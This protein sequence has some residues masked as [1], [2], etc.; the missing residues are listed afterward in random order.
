MERILYTRCSP[1][2]D[3]YEKDKINYSE[4][5]GISAVSAGYY[6]LIPHLQA[7]LLV[8]TVSEE[9][10]DEDVYEKIYEYVHLGGD[11]YLLNAVESL[12]LCTEPRVNGRSHRPI[13]LS[14]AIFGEFEGKPGA[15]LTD[16]NFTLDQVSQNER[17][18]MD[19]TQYP[20]P[21]PL[22]SVNESSLAK[23][24]VVLDEKL[25]KAFCPIFAYISAQL[26]KKETEQVPL[27]VRGAQEEVK[28]LVIAINQVLPLESAKRFTFLTHTSSFKN[29]PERYAYYAVNGDGTL[30]DYSP[31]NPE[32]KPTRHAKYLLVGHGHVGLSKG[33]VS[34]FEVFDLDT[35]V[36]SIPL[37]ISKLLLDLARGNPSAISFYESFASQN[38]FEFNEKTDDLY[39]VYLAVLGEVNLPSFTEAKRL[40]SA[41]FASPFAMVPNFRNRMVNALKESYPKWIGE[42]SMG[43]FSFLRT[44]IG[45]DRN[46]GNDMF[47]SAYDYVRRGLSSPSFN[48]VAFIAYSA[49]ENA[50]LLTEEAK[51]DLATSVNFALLPKPNSFAS[52]KAGFVS[53]L[54]TRLSSLGKWSLDGVEGKAF[55]S[56]FLSLVGTSDP[57]FIKLDAFLT[58]SGEEARGSVYRYFL[59][60]A[61]R[62]SNETEARALRNAYY[63]AAGESGALAAELRLVGPIRPFAYYERSLSALYAKSPSGIDLLFFQVLTYYPEAKNDS[64]TGNVL[65]SFIAAS[66]KEKAASFLRA[67]LPVVPS[68]K[69]EPSIRKFV[70]DLAQEAVKGIFMG[71]ENAYFD[72]FEIFGEKTPCLLREFALTMKNATTAKAQIGALELLGDYRI[73]LDKNSLGL[74]LISEIVASLIPNGKVYEAF[75]AH[76][77]VKNNVAL[78]FDAFLTLHVGKKTNLSEV[79]LGLCYLS[80][81]E[82]NVDKEV[83]KLLEGEDSPLVERFHEKKYE[84][85]AKGVL[86]GDDR[87]KQALALFEEKEKAY[88]EAHLSFFA[89]LFAKKKKKEEEA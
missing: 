44:C 28:N 4:G 27:F 40:T 82:G 15:Y 87:E 16:A 20:K 11:Y 14:E 59:T 74:P 89:R 22:P 29:N 2:L 10:C 47:A 85:F 32:L 18:Q 67:L 31:L 53:L 75:F 8:K 34:E 81:G 72:L 86:P 30:V 76:F 48:D 65:F 62:S 33:P 60:N 51:K 17:Y 54:L 39:G 6:D 42:D 1:W 78:T 52:A 70:K 45:L 5:Y 9:K 46:L 63:P 38:S 84:N 13:F 66:S 41:F 56:L 50:S 43:G 80:L 88:A 3:G 58:R 37:P 69:E 83:K 77:F 7:K 68:V 35:N 12:P 79:L 73:E 26:Q 24:S 21:A 71:K 55:S 57:L 36:S 19:Y 25:A 23:V 64:K 49:M 61:I